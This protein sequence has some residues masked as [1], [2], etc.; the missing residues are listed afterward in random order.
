MTKRPISVTIIGW[1]FVAAGITGI[2]YHSPEINPH[3]LFEADLLLAM[4]SLLVAILAGMFLLRGA[5]WARYLAL[6]WMSFHVV[7]S[8][9]HSM[10]KLAMHA[11]LLAGLAYFLFRKDAS[12]YFRGARS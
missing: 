8:A 6:L 3:A 2:G 11:V 1:I 12:E 5:N 9:M 10:P 4:S 7:M